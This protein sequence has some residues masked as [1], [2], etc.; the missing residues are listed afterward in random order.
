MRLRQHGDVR[1][2]C[3][4]MTPRFPPLASSPRSSLPLLSWPLP[5]LPPRFS[6][7]SPRP[8][9][10]SPPLLSFSLLFSLSRTLFPFPPS[11]LSLFR[12]LFRVRCCEA[13]RGSKISRDPR[14]D[15]IESHTWRRFS[16]ATPNTP[17]FELRALSYVRSS[18]SVFLSPRRFVFLHVRSFSLLPD[19]RTYVTYL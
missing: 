14:F 5:L 17:R 4:P 12:V 16:S 2:L 15:A 1:R 18:F 7:F 10:A 19:V 11:T 8:F 6:S 9:R 13:R 3:F